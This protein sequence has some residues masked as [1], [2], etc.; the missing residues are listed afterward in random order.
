MTL[1]RLLMLRRTPLTP[2][3]TDSRN[4]RIEPLL[5]RTIRPRGKLD[6]RMQ[7]YLH[8]W[9]LFLRYVHVVGVYTPQY[10]LVGD[11]DD[12]LTAF[13]FHDDGFETDDYVSI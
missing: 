8:P 3:R 2:K 5:L 4:I 10:G 1:L 13:E 9:A 7:W 12:V 6:K 11:N